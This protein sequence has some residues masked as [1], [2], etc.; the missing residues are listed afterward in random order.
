MIMRRIFYISVFLLL[1]FA[2]G[3]E[4]QN[5]VNSIYS[6][7]VYDVKAASEQDMK[8]LERYLRSVD[9]PVDE[10][11]VVE[12]E[13]IQENNRKAVEKF[14]SVAANI[15]YDSLR[16]ILSDDISFTYAVVC[17]SAAD[18]VTYLDRIEF[19]AAK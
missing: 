8:A 15:D 7:G 11:F 3:C 14:A 4:R 5:G 12:G 6:I 18:K 13:N 16:E 19:S 2:A 9:C 17:G 1:V 10:C